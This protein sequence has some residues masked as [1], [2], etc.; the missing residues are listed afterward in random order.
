[1]LILIDKRVPEE[2]KHHLSEYGRVVFLETSGIVYDS[3]SG[4]PD[5]FIFQ[6]PGGLVIAPCLPGDIKNELMKTG[7][8][9]IIGDQVLGAKYPETAFYNALYTSYG[10]LHNTIVSDPKILNSHQNTIHCRQ[11][12]TRCNAIQI[13]NIII[14]SDRGIEKTLIQKNIP[15][16]YVE[17]EGI[18]LQGFTNGFFGGCCGVHENKLFIC[19][20]LKHLKK[21][22]NIRKIANDKNFEIIELYPGPLLD[23]GGIFFI[24]NQ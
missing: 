11:A 17:P 9:V 8:P 4:H 24:D 22:N 15:V 16:F 7:I 20:S 18:V 23:V 3:I 14:T 2:V 13:G 1:M 19:G 5:I 12:Y 10:V 21:G 6:H